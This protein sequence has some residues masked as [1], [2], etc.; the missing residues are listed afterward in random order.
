MFREGGLYKFQGTQN[1]E[2]NPYNLT[3]PTPNAQTTNTVG[4]NQTPAFNRYNPKAT[5][6][7]NF[8]AFTEMKKR[9]LVTGNYNPTQS[10]DMSNTNNT[11]TTNTNTNT[12]NQNQGNTNQGGY[13]TAPGPM[14]QIFDMF[15]PIKKDFTWLSQRGPATFD[16]RVVSG[17]TNATVAGENTNLSQ[18]QINAMTGQ[19]PQAGYI[20]TFKYTKK[21]PFWNREKTLTVSGEWYDPNNPNAGK[22]QAGSGTTQNNVTANTGTTSTAQVNGAGPSQPRK[23]VASQYGFSEEEWD[24][25]SWRDQ[26]DAMNAIDDQTPAPTRPITVGAGSLQSNPNNSPVSSDNPYVQDAKAAAEGKGLFD[27]N[28][29]NIPG[30]NPRPNMAFPQNQ[31]GAPVNEQGVIR[32]QYGGYMPEYMAYGGYMPSYQGGGPNAGS[33]PFDPNNNSMANGNIGPCSEEQTLNAAPGDPCYNEGYSKGLPKSFSTTY[34]V[35]DAYSFKGREA[36]NL[37]NLLGFG[38]KKLDSMRNTNYNEDY[39][40]DNTT[41]DNREMANELDYA[42]GYSGLNQRIMTKGQGAGSTGFNRVVGDAAF[43][44]KGGELK[45]QRGGVYDLTQEEIGK[46]LAAGGQIK[47]I[48]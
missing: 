46:I 10:Y 39:L 27:P 45:Y 37:K 33:G 1:S 40:A 13:P 30:N 31:P 3:N 17:T 43:V 18:D 29:V 44:K 5:S 9:G 41:S 15:N 34:D 7:S 47:F 8:A 12:Q 11:T 20:P 23:S 4:P 2:T 16:G 22:S 25:M 38:A 36:S 24:N 21:G 28:S 26:T 48:K 35:K 42:G 6:G 19:K 14:R 32:R